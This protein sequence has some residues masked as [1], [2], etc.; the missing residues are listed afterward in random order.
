MQLSR[1]CASHL[2]I[3]FQMAG[4]STNHV[5]SLIEEKLHCRTM[6]RITTAQSRVQSKKYEIADAPFGRREMAS[7]KRWMESA[8]RKWQKRWYRSREPP[9]AAATERHAV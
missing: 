5:D 3:W 4:D 7:F 9:R 2:T 1:L 8:S 6:N